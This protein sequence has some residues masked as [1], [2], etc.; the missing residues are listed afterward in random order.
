[1]L[2][3]IL[4][5][6][7]PACIIILAVS[8]QTYA[9]DARNPWDTLNEAKSLK[10]DF[11]PGIST[12][13]KWDDPNPENIRVDEPVY[14]SDIDLQAGNARLVSSEGDRNVATKLSPMT[15]NFVWMSGMWDMSMITVYPYYLKDS[16]DFPA[17]WSRHRY[18][19][20]GP[21][22]SQVYGICRVAE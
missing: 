8:I 1:M 18:L 10:C 15:V 3:S 14:L 12:E 19:E 6:L 4:K 2:K 9:A 13:L 7:L 11:G 22:A 21:L 20:K 5:F 16:E 17:V